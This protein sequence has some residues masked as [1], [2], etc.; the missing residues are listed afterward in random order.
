MTGDETTTKPLKASD[1]FNPITPR[2]LHDQLSVLVD[3]CRIPL[4]LMGPSG[5]G[6]TTI[7]GQWA[8]EQGIAF[9]VLNYADR[10]P[11]EATG[12]GIPDHASREMWFA[13][14]DR[15]PSKKRIGDKKM[16][17]ILDEFLSWDPSIATLFH[18]ALFAPEGVPRFIGTHEIGENVMFVITTNLRHHGA[19]ANRCPIPVSG[20]VAMFSLVPAPDQ[21]VEWAERQPGY[22]ETMIPTFVAYQ[23][24]LGEGSQVILQ[25][26]I[27]GTYNP[28]RPTPYSCYRSW[29]NCCKIRRAH[30]TIQ[31]GG[32]MTTTERKALISAWGEVPQQAF[33][34]FLYIQNRLPDVRRIKEMG[35]A[36]ELPKDPSEQY[37]IV[38]ACLSQMLR[39]VNSPEVAMHQGDLDWFGHLLMRCRGEIKRY[40]AESALRRGVPFDQHSYFARLFYQRTA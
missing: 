11:Q 24:D 30:A 33:E 12:Y 39:G 21:W 6:K 36:Y 25:D 2:E 27:E 31:D 34:A 17:I 37:S 28:H 38:A 23:G 5:F 14:P 35:S 20:R 19:V 18:G 16:L 15:T 4:F 13:D 22:A 29:E 40:G 8:R 32:V 7:P 9:D 26:D 3:M 1:E 10:G